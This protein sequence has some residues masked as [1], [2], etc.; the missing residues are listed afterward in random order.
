[1]LS[2]CRGDIIIECFKDSFDVGIG[3]YNVER[4]VNE[5]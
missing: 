1:M 3:G 4:N 2:V 5:I